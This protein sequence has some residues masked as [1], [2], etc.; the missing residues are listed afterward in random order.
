MFPPYRI[1]KYESYFTPRQNAMQLFARS[2][3]AFFVF[4]FAYKAAFLFY[5]LPHMLLDTAGQKHYDN[6]YGN[7]TD[8]RK[9]RRGIQKKFHSD[10]DLYGPG[11]PSGD[12][13]AVP[14]GLDRR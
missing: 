8:F 1:K 10:S 9:T 6:H 11:G 2:A 12:P 4:F 14:D 13:P 7:D 3:G 5:I